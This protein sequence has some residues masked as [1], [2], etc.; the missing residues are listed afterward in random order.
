M[1]LFGKTLVL[2]NFGLSLMMAA[3]GGAVLYYRVDWADTPAAPDGSAPAGEIVARLDAVSKLKGVVPSVDSAWRDAR[4]SLLAQED[5]RKGDE[6]WYAV[7]LARLRT[8][9]KKQPILALVSAKDDKGRDTGRTVPDPRNGNL[10]QLAPVADRYGQPLQPL[11][12]YNVQFIAVNNDLRMRLTELAQ[13]AQDDET[14]TARLVG[15]KENRGLIQR[16]KDEQVKQRGLAEEMDRVVLAA[17]QVRADSQLLLL[18]K[19]ALQARVKE[20]EKTA[21]TAERP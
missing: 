11:D 20:L 15:T 9:P 1:D 7:E 13:A 21:A 18:R 16:T 8:D 4:T 6:A 10:P 2:I 12:V 5:R 14:L 17:G 3:V 19:R